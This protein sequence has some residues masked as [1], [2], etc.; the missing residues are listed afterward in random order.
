MAINC[1][2]KNS[3]EFKNLVKEV[4]EDKATIYWSNGIYDVK[5]I[6]KTGFQSNKGMPFMNENIK[7]METGDK[8]ITIRPKLHENGIY[9]FGGNNYRITNIYNKK[10]NV[11]SIKDV[12][13]LTKKFKGD[14]QLDTNNPQFKHITEWFKGNGEM[15]VYQ[16][17]KLNNNIKNL[18]KEDQEEIK[19]SE[20]PL[21]TEHENKLFVR[22][23][24]FISYQLRK[25]QRELSKLEQ[26]SP[27]LE[28]KQ[29]EV[30]KWEEELKNVTASPTEEG[31]TEIGQ[32]ILID[33]GNDLSNIETGNTGIVTDE[34]LNYIRNVIDAWGGLT[35]LK[36]PAARLEVRL[37]KILP[38]IIE[39]EVSK[40]ANED[41]TVPIAE[42]NAQ[43]EDISLGKSGLSSLIDSVN[44]IAKTIGLKI[45]ASKNKIAVENN[46]NRT[47]IQ[48]ELKKLEDYSKLS[49]K[50]MDDIWKLL[51]AE[52]NGT[53]ELISEYDEEGN[54]NPDF[55]N[56]VLNNKVLY[57]FYKFY[58]DRNTEMG[59]SKYFIAN[60]EE[61]NMKNWLKSINPIKHTRKGSEYD[62]DTSLD[63][64]PIKH[65]YRM[66]PEVKNKNLAL[67]MLVY[68]FHHNEQ[69][70]MSD[71]LPSLRL[72][73]EYLKFNDKDHSKE[74]QFKTY[75]NK[76]KWI[77]VTDTNLW[78][79][80]DK[81]IEIQVLGKTKNEEL[82][83]ILKTYTDS[84]GNEWE[85]TFNGRQFADDTIKYNSL[86]RIGGSILGALS[87][88]G[89]G[90]L[91]NLIEAIGGRFFN[92]KGLHE[93]SLMFGKQAT[94]KET[95]ELFKKIHEDLNFLQE[96]DD[97]Q[98]MEQVRL[99]GKTHSISP[100]KLQ[101]YLYSFQKNGENWI[102]SR[103][104]V[105]VMIKDGYI[106]DGKL[107]EKYNK[108][109]EEEK[110]RLTDK[111][112]RVNHTNHGRYTNKESAIWSQAL[113]YRAMSQF[114][115]WMY[116]AYEQRFGDYNKFDA[117]LGADIEGR[118]KT[119][120][121]EVFSQL[122]SNPKQ[123]IENLFLPI[124]SAKKAIEKGNLTEMEVA[125]M[126]KNMA[127]AI[128]I[129]TA[130][131][132]TAGLKGGDDEWKKRRKDPKFK[133]ALS[134]LNRISGDLEF[135]YNPQS[136]TQLIG[137]VA[138]VTKLYKDGISAM[139]YTLRLYPLYL[140]DW[141]IKNGSNKDNNKFYDKVG[142]DIPIIK[143]IK[144]IVRTL[145]KRSLEE[146]NN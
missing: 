12:E 15:Y 104:A 73:Q 70:E 47:Q 78:N 109:T 95:R 10:V 110:Q 33:I 58:Q 72:L 38:S 114:R 5:D 42:I 96:L 1:S 120:G 99:T 68:S 16:I 90:D 146:L 21:L 29:A 130:I 98:Y 141:K 129:A 51:T 25:S 37:N 133:F 49:G 145:N 71:I 124:I 50:S 65:H 100:E 76:S 103:S 101:E 126:R 132:L 36:T 56:N 135:F 64:V 67:A 69:T 35:E 92:V 17:E 45:S 116:S 28:S 143:P 46:K 137:N 138:P 57:N 8:R 14:D 86:V 53:T 24:Q 62:E 139:N 60:I 93:A 52:S 107:T 118:Y 13:H 91:S 102:Q 39:K 44:Y 79:Q 115:K 119:L 63:L 7:K 84:E 125:N 40:Y 34:W 30:N 123:A 26:D 3:V 27:L 87:N 88:I 117:R 55:E 4:G 134:L 74:R 20:I 19:K 127:E 41:R 6:P 77:N 85:K 131:L 61:K 142:K 83:K 136:A 105:A 94:S 54:I 11:S 121:R 144:D 80:I 122:L 82:Q 18:S 59:Q 128:M 9:S 111:I 75:S 89:F 81:W 108:A 97:Y 140:N 112:Q 106:K 32:K 48:E 31:F 66:S 113:A 22:Q 2:N 43:N 23:M